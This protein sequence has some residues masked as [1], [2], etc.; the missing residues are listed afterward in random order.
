MSVA[1]QHKPHL[2]DNDVPDESEPGAPPVQPD[3]GPVRT[4]IPAYPEHDRTANPESN[5]PR[6]PRPTTDPAR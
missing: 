5:Q 6:Q 1:H 4:P 2:P 3:D